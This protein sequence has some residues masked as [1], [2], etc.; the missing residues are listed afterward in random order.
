MRK[1][2][3][4]VGCCFLVICGI[5][6]GTLLASNGFGN[7]LGNK[8]T[9]G[10][11]MKSAGSDSEISY[12]DVENSDVAEYTV[13]KITENASSDINGEEL[14]DF[15]ELQK[16]Y[17]DIYAWITIDGT[18]VDY[19][20]LQHPTEDE[21]YLTHAYDGSDYIAGAVFTQGTYN[22]KTF[23]DPLTMIYA[24]NL[25]SGIM[26]GSLQPTYS[27]A[28]GFKTH[29]DIKIYLPGEVRH[30]TVFAA[31]PYDDQHILWS[32]DFSDEYWF[33]SFF[34]SIRQIRTLGSNFN[35]NLEVEPGDH[36]I[37]LSTCLRGDNTQRYLVMAVWN[38]DIK[39]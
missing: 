13:S 4:I 27:D 17:P 35:S 6:I 31:V 3:L 32:Y 11:T 15:T 16:K 24:H 28:E 2:Y 33:N 22:S 9:P 8:D 38:A 20:I 5:I 12:D 30:Y 21:F 37:V 36:V 10:K 25:K 14:V 18:R 26:F 1:V 39:S 23:D 29:S 19:P 7:F 34:T